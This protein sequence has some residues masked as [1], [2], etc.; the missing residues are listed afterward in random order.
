MS[1][2]GPPDVA[3]DQRVDLQRLARVAADGQLVVEEQRAGVDVVE[4]VLHVVLDAAQLLH[5]GI[6][7]AVH[8]QHFFIERLQ[9][10]FRGFQLFVG[11]LQFFVGGL[12]FLVGGFE[13]FVRR[14]LR[15][16]GALQ[17]FAGIGDFA[18]QFAHTQ[19]IGAGGCRAALAA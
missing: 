3:G 10:F 9:F 5:L 8:R 6:Q 7:F 16:D 1:A 11:A 4:Q 19:R 13:L 18:L 17:V 2:S 12:Q 14:L 15:L